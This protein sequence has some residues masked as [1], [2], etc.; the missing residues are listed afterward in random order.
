MLGRGSGLPLRLRHRTDPRDVVGVSLAPVGTTVTF[1]PPAPSHVTPATD[2]ASL[3]STSPRRIRAVKS[4]DTAD[5]LRWTV[6]DSAIGSVLLIASDHGVREVRINADAQDLNTYAES[7]YGAA[8]ATDLSEYVDA[9]QA[10]TQGTPTVP[11]T[12]DA[13]GSTFQLAVWEHL[14]TIPLGS[15]CT[16]S[17]VAEA[18]GRPTAVRAVARACATNPTALVVP[19]HRVVRRDGSLAGYRWGIAVKRALLG[20]EGAIC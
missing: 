5:R 12:R 14:T 18:L 13:P 19:C 16:Y 20:T 17:E 15:T 10:I 4:T 11:V 1:M 2:D 6:M 7:L 3:A 8:A 9:V